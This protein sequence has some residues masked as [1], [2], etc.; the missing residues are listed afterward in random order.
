MECPV[1]RNLVTPE[2]IQN[3]PPHVVALA[4]QCPVRC[5]NW[6]FGC[7][8]AKEWRD[9]WTENHSVN[10]QFQPTAPC[11]VPGC[12]SAAST[13]V[14]NPHEESHLLLHVRLLASQLSQAL[15]ANR[16]L[17]HEVDALKAALYA[18]QND[19]SHVMHRQRELRENEAS[20]RSQDAQNNEIDREQRALTLPQLVVVNIAPF[21]RANQE[22]TLEW[23]SRL[24]NR[25]LVIDGSAVSH[26]GSHRG[27][28]TAVMRQPTR[29]TLGC[30]A[31]VI[32][33]IR[34]DA[35]E[36]AAPSPTS[37]PFAQSMV[38]VGFALDKSV[39]RDV[40][41]NSV[42]VHL[43]SLPGCWAYQGS[44][45][46]WAGDA[47]QCTQLQKTSGSS[48]GCQFGIGDEV[49]CSVEVIQIAASEFEARVSCKK[50]GDPEPALLGSTIPL[51]SRP[52]VDLFA[53]VSIGMHGAT[54]AVV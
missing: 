53:A 38:M 5:G 1:D 47:K 24:L 10:C 39:L 35:G 51:G 49:R 2:S 46:V 27:W 26:S 13:H 52:S 44:G 3:A 8:W 45:F 33:S 12:S 23:D 41:H 48:D 36:A 9:W 25:T 43:G 15:S 11:D 4:E 14:A 28:G 18:V 37:T 54:V 21:A 31:V 22:E 19:V 34:T 29:A 32:F 17:Q 7:P 20:H 6:K 40:V 16:T 30:P 50:G 42:S